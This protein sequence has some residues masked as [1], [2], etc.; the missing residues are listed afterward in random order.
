MGALRR[1]AAAAEIDY[2]SLEV[3]D[4]QKRDNQVSTKI[5]KG[6]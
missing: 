1:A 5:E 3:L 6:N 2:K 4:R